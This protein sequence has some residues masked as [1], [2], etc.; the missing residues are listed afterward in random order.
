MQTVAMH[1]PGLSDLMCG[2]QVLAGCSLL[3]EPRLLSS[4]AGFGAVLATIAGAAWGGASKEGVDLSR[5]FAG[6]VVWVT[7]ASSGIGEAL[8]HELHRAGAR[9]VLSARRVGEL[10]RVRDACIAAARARAQQPEPTAPLVLPL[11]LSRPGDMK[12]KVAEAIELLGGSSVDVLVHNG[13]VSSRALAE[14]MDWEIDEQVAPSPACTPP[15]RLSCGECIKGFLPLSADCH[16]PLRV[17]CWKTAPRGQ[18]LRVNFLAP[19][20]LTK[21]L[22]PRM[23]TAR[24]G[25]FVVISSVQGLIGLPARSAYASSKHALHGFFDSLRA[26]VASRGVGVS[27]ICPGYVRTALS[28]NAVTGTGEKHG[29]MDT[30][31]AKGMDPAIFAQRALAAVARRESQVVIADDISAHVA[32]YLRVL[33]PN[34]LQWVMLKRA[35]K[36]LDPANG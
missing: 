3:A 26:E 18:V 19:V 10:E 15:C 11:D 35:K 24:R 34:I 22:L 17:T 21:A 20:A 12:S 28:L 6:K 9:V 29:I 30:T 8:A 32:P 2:W 33:S 31:T 27:L 5:T 25:Q 13:G 1:W 36:S 16:R 4:I 14:E 23:L 7:G